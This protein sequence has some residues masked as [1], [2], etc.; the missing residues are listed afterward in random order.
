ME[1]P[2]HDIE[3]IT[4]MVMES[5]AGISV[6]PVADEIGRERPALSGCVS[7]DGAWNGAVIVEC[8]LSLAR[9]I[10]EALLAPPDGH[11]SAEDVSDALGE[12]TNIVG[13]NIKAL[14]PPPSRLSLPTVVEGADYAVTV[15]RTKPG[16]V[17]RFRAGDELLV[18]RILEAT[19][20]KVGA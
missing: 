15:P 20:S 7:I 17:A 5:T 11:V 13:G 1:L 2:Q 14:L 18:V 6:E 16:P 19:G 4:T 10:T 12:I 3:T 9:R 8:E